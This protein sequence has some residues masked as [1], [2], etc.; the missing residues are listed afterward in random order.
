MS[1]IALILLFAQFLVL[2]KIYPI[3][4]WSVLL[5]H[6]FNSGAIYPYL[7]TD[8]TADGLIP[9][10]LLISF[11]LIAIIYP[12]TMANLVSLIIWWTSVYS[13]NPVWAAAYRVKHTTIA[14]RKQQGF[15][16]RKVHGRKGEKR[17][18]VLQQYDIFFI[19]KRHSFSHYTGA[20]QTARA[21]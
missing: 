19:R 12:I 4:V 14:C 2:Q 13:C 1:R 3:Y 15:L 9:K 21:E 10:L 7:T 8:E 17:L 16:S 20:G 6:S 18:T 5:Y 11:V